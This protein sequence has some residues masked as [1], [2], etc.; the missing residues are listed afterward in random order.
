LVWPKG[1]TGEQSA[2]SGNPLFGEAM[3]VHWVFHFH[4]CGSGLAV[5]IYH[6]ATR[7]AITPRGDLQK[8]CSLTAEGNA[9]QNDVRSGG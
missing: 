7:R 9:A 4:I 6:S 2:Q 8:S 5:G 1:S 3:N